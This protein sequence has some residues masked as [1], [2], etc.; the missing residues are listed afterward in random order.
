MDTLN[1]PNQN[2]KGMIKMKRQT[3][4]TF[5]LNGWYITLTK[6][7]ESN[8]IGNS[9][10]CVSYTHTIEGIGILNYT[11]LHEALDKFNRLITQAFNN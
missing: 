9:G 2:R 1:Y 4:G 11:Y 5:E 6:N 3:I 7:A 8:V 10:Y